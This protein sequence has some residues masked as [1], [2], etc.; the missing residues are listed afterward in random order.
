MKTLRL[1]IL[2][3]GTVGQGIVA[4]LQKNQLSWQDKTG[5]NVVVTAIAK[6]NWDG[7]DKPVGIDCINDATAIVNRDDVDV[8]LELI[9]GEE[10][11]YE[12]ILRA[13][14]NNKHVVTANKALIASK[15][16]EIFARAAEKGVQVAFE[17]SVAGGIPIIKSLKEGL[18]ANEINSVAGIINGTSNYILTAMRNEGRAFG[19]VLK[20][21]QDLGYA[22]S[23]PTFDV[24]GIDA[25]HKLTILASIAYGVALDLDKVEI[26]GISHIAPQDVRYAETLGYRIKHLGVALRRPEGIEIRVHPT[27]VPETALISKVDGV[28]NAVRVFGNAVGET[29]FYGAGAGSL[30]TASA[31]MADVLGL[32]TNLTAGHVSPLGYANNSNH[33]TRV[34]PVAE[35]QSANYL[36]FSVEDKPGVLADVTRIFA[37]QSISIE[38]L[39]QQK[40][41][42][43]AVYVPIV[44]VT[45]VVNEADLQTAITQIA[46]LDAVQ[47][48]VHRIRVEK[49]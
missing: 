35:H 25:A 6:R 39:L 21:A 12:L 11:A 24:E 49:F 13:I 20:E 23:D 41:S 27:L 28:M 43:N 10:A 36:R 47:G 30:P 32:V 37:N 9:G 34:L 22:E 14:E 26:E 18:I 2:G 33:S 48:D 46:Q 8:V 31:V 19:E 16:R 3:Y 42:D 5:C 45:P 40:E 4:L 7:I 15:G 44:I 38:A 29:L 1:G 17:A